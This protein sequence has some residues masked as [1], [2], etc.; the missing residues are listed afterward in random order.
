MANIVG[1]KNLYKFKVNSTLTL[2]HRLDEQA[3]TKHFCQVC[4][5]ICCQ[6]FR[7]KPSQR[8]TR[9]RLLLQKKTR[10]LTSL[11]VLNKL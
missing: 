8:N 2:S 6:T 4:E 9:G 11:I 1:V 5:L 3:Q 10:F 7:N